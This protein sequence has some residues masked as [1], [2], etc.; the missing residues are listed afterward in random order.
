MLRGTR[1]QDGALERYDMVDGTYLEFELTINKESLTKWKTCY[2]ITKTNVPAFMNVPEGT[3]LED[4]WLV[5][6][7][8]YNGCPFMQ[9]IFDRQ[10]RLANQEGMSVQRVMVE[11]KTKSSMP[12]TSEQMQ[13]IREFKIRLIDD[14]TQDLQGN[15]ISFEAR[16]RWNAT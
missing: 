3:E 16:N 7:I 9:A 6:P 2:R 15:Q 14:F 5:K 4:C 12:L 1:C 10:G 11:W 8:T 13:A